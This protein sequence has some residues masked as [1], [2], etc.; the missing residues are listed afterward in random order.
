MASKL[1]KLVLLL[2]LPT[3]FS[4]DAV[5]TGSHSQLLGLSAPTVLTVSY[6]SYYSRL[7]EMLGSFLPGRPPGLGSP[8]QVP[9]QDQRS[10]EDLLPGVVPG[11]PH[12]QWVR[13]PV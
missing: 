5:M 7:D 9:R 3:V 8:G 12:H 10:G 4:V 2:M 1:I 6:F 11:A 13:P